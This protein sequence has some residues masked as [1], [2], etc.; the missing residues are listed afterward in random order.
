V[1]RQ[2]YQELHVTNLLGAAANAVLCAVLLVVARRSSSV[3]MFVCLFTLIPLAGR[4]CNCGLL[5]FRRPYLIEAT[6][7]FTL[8]ESQALL[9]D[10]V[11]YLA[12]SFTAVLLYQW[13]VYWMVRTHS[14]GESAEFAIGT[15]MALLPISFVLGFIQP[16]WSSVA[17]AF[18][19]GDHSWLRLQIKTWRVGLA[20]AGGGCFLASLFVGQQAA[21]LWLRTPITIGWQV[22]GLIGAY[23][24][25]A[26]WEYFHFIVALGVGRLREA[27]M[28]VFLRSACFAIAVP[29]LAAGGGALAL[30][31]GLCLSILLWTAWRLPCALPG[32]AEP[33][34]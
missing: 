31:C 26:I 23:I 1:I 18:A 32:R 15:Q 20:V 28:G 34:R 4:L 14:S 33:I 29:A 9:S 3:C 30:W 7:Q 13:P 16:L 12:S 21:R 22:R 5:L 6:G 8:Q 10:G 2:A 19:R 27:T 11:R 25:F 24:A 17:D